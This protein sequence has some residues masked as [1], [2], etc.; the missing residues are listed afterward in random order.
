MTKKIKKE[1][2]NERVD[3]F[4]EEINKVQEKHGLKLVIKKR[5]DSYFA[6]DELPKPAPPKK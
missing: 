3:K 5:T 4:I 6:V 1:P 2:V